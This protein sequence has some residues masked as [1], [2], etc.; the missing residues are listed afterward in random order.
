MFIDGT[1]PPNPNAPHGY[2][3][4]KS[5]MVLGPNGMPHYQ[6]AYASPTDQG[7]GAVYETAQ[8][9]YDE[10]AYPPQEG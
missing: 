3:N 10:A 6:Q 1:Y 9:Q 5:V 7:V 2:I 8:G 4:G